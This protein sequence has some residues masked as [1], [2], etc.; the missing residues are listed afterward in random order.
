VRDWMI[1]KF[2]ILAIVSLPQHTFAHVKA[3]V[4]SSVL[5][6]RKHPKSL[7]QKFEQTLSDIKALV[8]EERGLD[9]EQQVARILELYQEKVAKFYTNYDILMVEVENIGYDST[10]KSIKGNELHKVAKLIKE[11]IDASREL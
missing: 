5:F 8:K 10:G 9:K 6:L 11:K 1:E 3:G 7:T 4:K 2:R